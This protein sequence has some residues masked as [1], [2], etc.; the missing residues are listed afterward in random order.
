M[1]ILPSRSGSD[2]YP[3]RA[4]SRPTAYPSNEHYN[5]GAISAYGGNASSSNARSYPSTGSGHTYTMALLNGANDGGH[6]SFT[7]PHISAERHGGGSTSPS[8][9]FAQMHGHEV[10]SPCEQ[11]SKYTAIRPRRDQAPL[12]L[13]TFDLGVDYPSE[14]HTH[15]TSSHSDHSGDAD[16]LPQRT[17]GTSPMPSR[18][19]KP[20]REKPRIDL[21][22]DQPPTTQGKP[23]ARVYVACLQWSVTFYIRILRYSTPIVCSQL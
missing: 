7:G 23:R 19:R 14:R 4:N 20:R 11:H 3:Q 21:A 13:D 1:F 22:P 2:S 9:A 15:S 5:S 6:E 18:P 10:D 12:M 8:Q 16:I 17:K